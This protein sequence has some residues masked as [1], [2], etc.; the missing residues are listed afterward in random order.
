M[1]RIREK[2]GLEGTLIPNK[3][4]FGAG[5]SPTYPLPRIIYIN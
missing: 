4:S 1:Q 3:P 5:L 2:F